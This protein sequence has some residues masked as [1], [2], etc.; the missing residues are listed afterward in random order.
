M[1][2]RQRLVGAAFLLMLGAASE[3]AAQ[4]TL[5]AY[6][7]VAPG[8][9]RTASVIATSYER[10][11]VT[12]RTFEIFR[13]TEPVVAWG[14]GVE[15]QFYKRVAIAADVGAMHLIEEPYYPGGLLAVNGAYHFGESQQRWVPFLAAGYSFGLDA[16]RGF[17]GAV[18]V[19]YWFRQR[20]GLRLELRAT[21]LK[22]DIESPNWPDP[23]E[24]MIGF[25]AGLNFAR[26]S[27]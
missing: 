2:G 1:R 23:S 8:I 5:W 12:P 13:D 15:W 27:F 25:R 22:Y 9:Y 10:D 19:N 20:A 24:W 17:D 11:F 7:F 14:G 26:R 3:A 4:S 16:Q 18:G 6:G 21:S